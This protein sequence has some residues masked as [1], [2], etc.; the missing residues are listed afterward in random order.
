MTERES[1]QCA[2]LLLSLAKLHCLDSATNESNRNLEQAEGIVR[3][4]FQDQSLFAF[5]IKSARASI[6]LSQGNATAALRL[7]DQIAAEP[8]ERRRENGVYDKSP[9]VMAR[10]ECMVKLRRF[11]DALEVYDVEVPKMCDKFGNEH[12]MFLEVYPWYSKTLM[13]VGRDDQACEIQTRCNSIR[14]TLSRFKTHKSIG[15]RGGTGE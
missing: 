4:H 12:P 11:H 15:R 14:S 7:L 6:L 10:A 1:G 13:A 9:L 3:E 8:P 5:S 2:A